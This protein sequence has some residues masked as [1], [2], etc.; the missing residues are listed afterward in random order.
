MKSKRFVNLGIALEYD[1]YS[2]AWIAT[3]TGLPGHLNDAN[4]GV[5]DTPPAAVADLL[6]DLADYIEDAERSATDPHY[7]PSWVLVRDALRN[8]I[9]LGAPGEVSDLE[10]AMR[11][12]YALGFELYFVG[13]D[14]DGPW[15]VREACR[16]DPESGRCEPGKIVAQ[17]KAWREAYERALARELEGSNG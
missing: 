5:G 4:Y 8:W 14:S 12:L 10:G 9:G 16:C 15:F 11:R 2:E 13:D 3:C 6:H 1:R 17:G 7:H